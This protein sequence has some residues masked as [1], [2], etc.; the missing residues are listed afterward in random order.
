MQRVFITVAPSNCQRSARPR[1]SPR[2]TRFGHIITIS[3][4][5]AGSNIETAG[6]LLENNVDDAAQTIPAVRSEEHTSELQS[7]MRN[8]YAVLCL[9]KKKTTVQQTQ[10]QK[11][12]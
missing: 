5:V 12:T 7:L 4:T 11:H 3:K 9:K 1:F 6:I 8:S 2:K 10:T